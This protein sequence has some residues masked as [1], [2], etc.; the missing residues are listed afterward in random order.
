MLIKYEPILLSDIYILMPTSLSSGIRLAK[1]KD[2]KHDRIYT[3][4]C[5]RNSTNN[6]TKGNLGIGKN[7]RKK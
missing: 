3:L 6:S 4:E 2:I 7:T 5:Q 1:I